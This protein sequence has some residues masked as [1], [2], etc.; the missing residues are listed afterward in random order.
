MKFEG[1]VP[2][3]P[4]TFSP[5][6]RAFIEHI[7]IAL[8]IYQ[9]VD[10]T[11]TPLLVSQ[12]Y[13]AL[14]GHAGFESARYTLRTDLYHN[15][16]PEDIPRMEAAS[17][18]FAKTPNGGT[19]DMLFRNKRADQADYHIIHGTGQYIKID[20]TP[21][22]FI[23]YTDETAGSENDQMVK[24]VLST[25]SAQYAPT[26]S[27]AYHAHFDQLTGLANMAHFLERAGDGIKRIQE[28]GGT[29]VLMYF[30]LRDLKT[31]NR[32]MGFDAGDRQICALAEL[33]GRYFGRDCAA[34]FESDH[35]A[36]YAENRH[37]ESRL[38][39]LFAQMKAHGQGANLAVKVGL[40]ALPDDDTRLGEACDRARQAAAA[41]PNGEDS[42]FLWF[43]DRLRIEN[44]LRTYIIRHLGEAMAHGWI[45]VYYQP[46]VRAMTQTVCNGEALVRWIDPVH[47]PLSPGQFIPVLE[48]TGQITELDLYVFEQ[49][50]QDHVRLKAD[51]H[52]PIPVSINLSRRDFLQDDLPETLDQIS[53]AYGVPREFT[54]LEITE[55]AFVTQINKVEPIIRRLHQLGYHIWMDDFGT[56]YSSLSVLKKYA[57][58]EL[59]IDMSFLADFDDKAKTLLTAIVRMAKDLDIS[60]LAEGVETEAQFNFLK[61]IG[62]EKIQGYYF[63]RPMPIDDLG[64]HFKTRG[65]RV[66]PTKWRAY[67]TRLSRIDTLTDEPLCIV[68]DD[69]TTF[70]ILFANDAYKAALHKDHVDDLLA[71]QR[72]INTPGEPIH[73][74]H[75]HYADQQ[76]RRLPGPQTTLYPSGDHY[77]QLTGTV[78]AVQDDHYLYTLQIRYVSLNVDDTQQV[79]FETTSELYYA[80]RDIAHYDLNAHTVAGLKSSLYSQPMGVGV[81]HHDVDAVVA[82]WIKAFCY[83]PDRARFAAFM[84]LNTLQARLKENGGRPLT[85]LFRSLTPEGDYRWRFHLILPVER[86]GFS[87]AVHVTLDAD[88]SSKGILE[89]ADA[90]DAESAPEDTGISA[91][92]LWNNLILNAKHMYFWKDT[93][94]RFLGA[95]QSFC[96]YF[97]VKHLGE[98]L[99]KT[100]EDMGWHIDPG[101]FKQDEEAVLTAGKKLY[102]RRGHCLV[103]GTN[104]DI[105]AS[106]VPVYQDGKIVGLLGSVVDAEASFAFF[107]EEHRLAATDPVTGLANTRGLSDGLQAYLE[108]H[109]RTGAPFAMLDITVPEYREVV[110]LYGAASGNALL[111]RVGAAITNCAGHRCVVGRTQGSHFALITA[112]TCKEEVRALALNIRGAITAMRRAGQWSGNL[113]A[114]LTASY[115]DDA[116]TERAAYLGG[117]SG[118]ILNTDDRETL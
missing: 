86:S 19:Y 26:E 115:S 99:G 43:D 111:K 90:L 60:T 47:G 79:R 92:L 93:H 105:I 45:K 85:G 87:R 7:P 6:T 61:K 106:K 13:L 32:R 69:G 38:Q 96:D 109:W 101:P 114:L 28:T 102:C 4:Y 89:V 33:I 55:S 82:A 58:D 75:R 36:A 80:C 76:L 12:A 83:P 29:P 97:G 112:F 113:S 18:A 8:A 110:D 100:D 31:Y 46:V 34:R 23:T 107:S 70:D 21:M 1:D 63:A 30:D 35:F 44:A 40:Y 50:C 3:K 53:S 78:A 15:V 104:R 41:I 9:Y 17:L 116:S 81:E 67:F 117:L 51:G 39:A 72:V 71:W 11:I 95:S 25:L 84:D 98:L 24:A 48:E 77:M 54:N 22:A 52:I 20:G 5:E 49:V 56:G 37:L 73:T 57:F 59:K 16:H 103:G 74:L 10:G 27:P 66:E 108:E 91:A 14:F 65:I 118:L 64:D 68:N 62:C 2:V 88:V 42:A 94:R